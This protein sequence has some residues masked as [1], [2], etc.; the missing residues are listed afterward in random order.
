MMKTLMEFYE[1]VNGLKPVV[2]MVVVQVA[3]GG[4]NVLY[5]LAIS[6]GMSARIIAAYRYIFATV[7]MIPLALYFEK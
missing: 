2:V 3:Y 7:F 5:K 4:V 6:N 1:L